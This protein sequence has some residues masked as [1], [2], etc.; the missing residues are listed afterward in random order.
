M[1]ELLCSQCAESAGP[2]SSQWPAIPDNPQPWDIP[3]VAPSS[4]QPRHEPTSRL[5][6][7]DGPPLPRILQARLD[8]L[9]DVDLILD[10]FPGRILRQ[11]L[12][13][14]AGFFLDIRG[15]HVGLSVWAPASELM[16]SERPSTWNH[17]QDRPPSAVLS[18]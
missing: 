11:S 7:G 6:E 2:N 17:L 4:R 5:R 1:I 10:I 14:P 15:G 12:D 9:T 16:L 8:R 18:P 3:Q 13:E